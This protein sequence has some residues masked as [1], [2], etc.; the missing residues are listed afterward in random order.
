[1][2]PGHCHGDSLTAI[3]ALLRQPFSVMAPFYGSPSRRYHDQAL[4]PSSPNG[5]EPGVCE[6]RLC[7][8]A[9]DRDSEFSLSPTH[10]AWQP[11]HGGRAAGPGTAAERPATGRQALPSVPGPAGPGRLGRIYARVTFTAG[12]YGPM[13]PGPARAGATRGMTGRP[14]AVRPRLDPPRLRLDSER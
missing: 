1:M 6:A 11:G 8:A 10:A 14:I 12:P 5:R 9:E 4:E 3:L 7:T 2:L 13:E